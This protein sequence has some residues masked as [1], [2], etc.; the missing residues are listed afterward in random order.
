M[1]A[2]MYNICKGNYRT[3]MEKPPDG[4]TEH[5]FCNRIY[6]LYKSWILFPFNSIHIPNVSVGTDESLRLSL[7]RLWRKKF[8]QKQ[9]EL[10]I[11]EQGNFGNKPRNCAANFFKSVSTM[12]NDSRRSF[13]FE[14]L[15]HSFSINAS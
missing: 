1:L 13:R 2:L 4:Q 9:V 7:G 14:F 11:K 6:T 5:T 8:L 10:K 15:K 12:R 3:R